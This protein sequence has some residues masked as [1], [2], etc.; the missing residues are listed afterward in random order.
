M[1]PNWIA[2]CAAALIITLSAS[3][4]S[5]NKCDGSDIANGPFVYASL[6]STSTTFNGSGGMVSTSF[7][8]TAPTPSTD[9]ALPNVFPGQGQDACIGQ[10]DASF[11][12]FEIVQV[13]D[14]S[15]NLLETPVTVSSSSPLYAQIA[16]AFSFNPSGD[17]FTPGFA[18]TISVNITNPNV[19][20]T[21]YGVYQVKLAAQAPGAGIGVGAGVTY[22]LSLFAPTAS[23][24]TPPTVTILDPPVPPNAT[25]QQ[26]LGV[27]PVEIQ[28]IDPIGTPPTGTGVASM[29]ATVSSLGGAVS[30]LPITLTPNPAL[31]VAAG[32]TVDST[33]TFTPTGGSG[34]AGTSDSEA[35]QAGNLSGI[36]F[37]RLDAQA[38]D[39]AGNTGY[40]H[41][42]FRVGY[43]IG[44]AKW[45]STDPTH[46]PTAGNGNCAG[47]LQFT[48]NRSSSTSD[49][50]PMYDQTVVVELVRSDGTIVATHIWGTG[51]VTSFVQIDSTPVYKTNFKRGDFATAPATYVAKIFFVDVD[52]HLI[53]QGTT[54]D[55]SF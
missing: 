25:A 39:G 6:G 7:S 51:A 52:G 30:N 31:A 46:C 29:S 19:D 26:I 22:S 36:G 49:G 5:S 40:A 13:A 9:T 21:N 38:T 47:Q 44:I 16:A 14:A 27:I 17:T 42:V 1:R 48:V 50:A 34:V 33:G 32:V 20:S 24:T 12:V 55:L 11:G 18:D 8:V 28:A 23:D 10:A 43:Q 35:F 37:Y 45:Q 4:Q 15:G 3:A 41:R 2:A 54:A 53:Q